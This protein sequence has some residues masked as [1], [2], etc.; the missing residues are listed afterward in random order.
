MHRV[1]LNQFVDVCVISANLET[2]FTLAKMLVY[3]VA[4][5][6]MLSCENHC[7]LHIVFVFPRR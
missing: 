7:P 3:D 6:W 4:L 5:K 1:R 2:L